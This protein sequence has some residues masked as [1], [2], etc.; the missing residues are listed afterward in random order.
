MSFSE[1]L[2]KTRFIYINCFNTLR[3]LAEFSTKFAENALFGQFKDQ[4][5]HVN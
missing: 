1:K 4:R 3:F 5:K 2:I